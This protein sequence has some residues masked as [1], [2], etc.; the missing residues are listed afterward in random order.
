MESSIQM[1]NLLAQR[2]WLV[3]LARGLVQDPSDAE[4]L[5]QGAM[6]LAIEK[7]P[8]G[9]RSP[10][11]WL[12]QVARNLAA[13][14]RS[15]AAARRHREERSA[16]TE[17]L[18]STAELVASTEVHRKL[19]AEVM[20]LQEPYRSTLVLHY[21]E[22]LSMVEI[23]RRAGVAPSTVRT[24]TARGLEQLRTR[25]DAGSGGRERWMAALA[26]LVA[27]E[28]S[29]RVGWLAAAGAT[30]LLGGGAYAALQWTGHGAAAIEAPSSLVQAPQAPGRQIELAAIS[31]LGAGTREESAAQTAPALP[32]AP[33]ESAALTESAPDLPVGAI[34]VHVLKG[35][36]PL[37]GV[38]VL[39]GYTQGYFQ[40]PDLKPGSGLGDSMVTDARGRARFLGIEA[41][42]WPITVS[43]GP[44]HLRQVIVVLTEDHGERVTVRLGEESIEGYVFDEAGFPVA[45]AHIAW[46]SKLQQD[47]GFWSFATSRTD[48]SYR[49]DHLVQ[50]LAWLDYRPNG[51]LAQ[52]ANMAKVTVVK[53]ETLTWNFGSQKGKSTH[54]CRLVTSSGAPVVGKFQLSLVRE[55]EPIFR[56]H[57]VGEDTET[58]D[59]RLE[60][61]TWSIQVDT[62]TVPFTPRLEAA[63]WNIEDIDTDKTIVLPGFRVAGQLQLPSGTGG[64]KKYV[65]LR[66]A[67]DSFVY[68]KAAWADDG[69]WVLD[70]VPP[71]SYDIWGE[72]HDGRDNTVVQTIEVIDQD[73][74]LDL[75][76]R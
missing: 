23:G 16:R 69:R 75:I 68:H 54:R 45:G 62:P 43:L 22:G 35:E 72:V 26:P 74:V 1:E 30:L 13:D 3:R 41:G 4:D 64:Y 52:D 19:G 67:N 9:L 57:W 8:E 70:A 53:G 34:E 58:F 59:L 11:A 29:S 42:K 56:Q 44:G 39:R 5:A 7:Q 31:S 28:S 49:L 63:S 55:D 24:R 36:Q 25:M 33:A 10:R 51:E 71:G 15:S 73:L 12:A 66:P 50:G 37:A 14:K 40:H 32:P 17:A 65:T 18:G 46:N 60:P 6:A 27:A 21:F 76:I 48:G 47:G 2:G 61:G 38:T 20:A